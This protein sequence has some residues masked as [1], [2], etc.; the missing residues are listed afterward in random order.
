MF[1]GQG[2]QV[3]PVGVLPGV[4]PLLVLVGRAHPVAVDDRAV[5]DSDRAPGP[6]GQHAVQAGG[7][8][9]EPVDG[10]D[11]IPVGGGGADAEGDRSVGVRVAAAQVDQDPQG[12][13]CG[14]WW[15][16]ARADIGTVATDHTVGSSTSRPAVLLGHAR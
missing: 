5:E 12:L 1:V 7:R 16:P 14:G 11:D 6:A 3:D 4:V 2:L 13:A 15:P 10:L 9:G 8:C